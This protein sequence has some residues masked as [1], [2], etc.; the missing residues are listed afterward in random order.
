MN[1]HVTPI[2]RLHDSLRP[3][4]ARV[5]EIIAAQVD[6]PVSLVPKIALHLLQAGGKRIRPLLL[7]ASA[8]LF[9]PIPEAAL[10]LAASI[11]FIHTA[12]LL[13]DDVI[14]E[15]PLRRGLPTAHCLWGNQASILVGDFLFGRSFQ[16]MVANGNKEILAVLARV[17]ARISEGEVSQ[18]INCHNLEMP[19]EDMMAILESKT[20]ELFSAACHVGA[21][22]SAQP[23]SIALKLSNFGRHFGLAFQI[24]DDILDYIGTSA[25]RGKTI[26]DDFRE[27]KV[28]L[29]VLLTYPHCTASEQQFWRETL[30][31]ESSESPPFLNAEEKLAEALGLLKKY[32]G[33]EKAREM[34]LS[35]AQ[36]AREDLEGLPNHP[37]KDL[38][39]EMTRDICS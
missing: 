24:Q 6:S 28:T 3:E 38:F 16:L 32:D 39:L 19:L 37:L 36:K 22:T 11:E 8:Q 13:H 1:L 15:S 17:A 21:L 4:M 33:L 27:G 29:P 30:G 12:T 20:A 35:Y 23:E 31:D 25:L 5:N 14:D 26:G 9:G 10:F 7:L 2:H 34:A 18:L